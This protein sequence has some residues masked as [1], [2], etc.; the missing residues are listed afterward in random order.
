MC[1]SITVTNR[2]ILMQNADMPWLCSGHLSFLSS[3]LVQPTNSLQGTQTT[4]SYPC[5]L[6]K[7]IHL[8]REHLC[9]GETRIET[10][11]NIQT[12]I[13]QSRFG[14]WSKQYFANCPVDKVTGFQ[15]HFPTLKFAGW[16]LPS[17]MIVQEKRAGFYTALHCREQA[18]V[19]Q[20]E[21]SSHHLS[22]YCVVIWNSLGHVS[23]SKTCFLEKIA[24]WFG[25]RSGSLFS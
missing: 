17:T 9:T 21:C 1:A 25:F 7:S 5:I 19:F 2:S 24:T 20:V 11:A 10:L 6:G 18:L 14:G 15:Y 23:N 12:R 8:N 13:A 22:T 16:V 3:L 4:D